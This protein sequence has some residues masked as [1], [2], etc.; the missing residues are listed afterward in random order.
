MVHSMTNFDMFKA[1]AEAAAED[2]K[3]QSEVIFKAIDKDSNGHLSPL[4]LGILLRSYGLPDSEI[5]I[6][7]QNFSK[8]K[9]DQIGKDEFFENFKPLWQWSYSEMRH[10]F[11]RIA[12]NREREKFLE[13]SHEENQSKFDIV[14]DDAKVNPL[15][16]DQTNGNDE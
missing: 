4:E 15:S 11:A 1:E 9:G 2:T 10:G 3:L 14:M 12:A 5:R 16:K 13:V 8:S 7:F 6:I